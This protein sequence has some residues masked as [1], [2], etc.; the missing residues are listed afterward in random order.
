MG[1]TKNEWQSGHSTIIGRE[2]GKTLHE[3]IRRNL[4][5]RRTKLTSLQ[6]G[7]RGNVVVLVDD[8]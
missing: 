6:N 1:G 8:G 2:Y 7:I 3:K 5:F 4:S